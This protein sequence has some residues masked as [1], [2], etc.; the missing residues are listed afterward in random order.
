M[1]LSWSR[2]YIA[3]AAGGS[4]FGVS[5][6]DVKGGVGPRKTNLH[7]QKVDC[8]LDGGNFVS[9]QSCDYSYTNHPKNK[10]YILHYL[11]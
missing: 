11:V 4:S 5:S 1:E 3:V 7:P 2:D 10:G 9:Y 6:G 8:W